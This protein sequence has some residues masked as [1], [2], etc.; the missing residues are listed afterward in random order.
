MNTAASYSVLEAASVTSRTAAPRLILASGFQPDYVRE[1]ANAHARLGSTVHVVGGDMHEQQTYH[2]NVS[3]LNLRGRDEREN[4]TLREIA[5]LAGYLSRLVR[6]VCTSDA[7]IVYDVSIGRPLLRCLLM[8]P[9]FRLAGKRIVYTAHNVLPHDAD[10][11]ANRMVYWFIY[12]LLAD[13]IVV[14]GQS[15]KERLITEFNVQP[16]RVH[17]VAHGT[18]HPRDTEAITKATARKQLGIAPRER[19]LL[20]FGLQRH[21]KGTH[22]V[23]EALNDYCAADLVLVVRGHAP[24]EAYKEFLTAQVRRHCGGLRINARLKAVSD[25]EME[26][27]FK[28]ADIVL[29]PYLEGSQ[30]G[31]KFMAYAYGRPVLASET[32]SLR[33]YIQPG[34]SGET[35]TMADPVAFRTALERMLAHL[36]DYSDEKILAYAREH[37]SFDAAATQVAALCGRLSKEGG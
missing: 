24:D 19:V 35:F 2:P 11:F 27:V 13:S 14:H 22:F 32:G 7:P 30:S 3:L 34:I 10:T 5:K 9:L 20:C 18:Y 37:C 4:S 31:I 16:E 21:Y 26:V 12:R 36:A 1:I 29:L 25:A 28:A 23:L 15:L 33:E 6:T 17:T 8:Y